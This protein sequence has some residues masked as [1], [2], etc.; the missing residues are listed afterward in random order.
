MK[1]HKIV[2]PF[3]DGVDAMGMKNCNTSVGN[4]TL[5][6]TC[7]CKTFYSIVL[8]IKI[9]LPLPSERQGTSC[10]QE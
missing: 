3:E 7:R 10:E 4:M 9:V 8:D 1:D 6:T 5:N 2:H